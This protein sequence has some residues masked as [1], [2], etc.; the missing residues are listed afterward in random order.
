M[1]GKVNFWR[2]TSTLV[3]WSWLSHNVKLTTNFTDCVCFF[4]LVRAVCPHYHCDTSDYTDT[5]H[6][7]TLHWT[8]LASL[9]RGQG[10]DLPGAQSI[11]VSRGDWLHWTC[12]QKKGKSILCK[13]EML[14]K[15][16]TWPVPGLSFWTP[17]TKICWTPSKKIVYQKKT[18]K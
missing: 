7:L 2:Q 10:I 11:R 5:S 1:F 16:V 12:Y 17:S 6:P 13:T 3:I 8:S 14:T 9:V 4:I 18:K 15:S